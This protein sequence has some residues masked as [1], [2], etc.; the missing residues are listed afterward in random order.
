MRFLLSL[1]N[2]IARRLVASGG[3]ALLFVTGTAAQTV[4]A[5]VASGAATTPVSDAGIRP[6]HLWTGAYMRLVWDDAV[7][8][9]TAPLHW[10]DGQ[11]LK[12]GGA[13]AAV[14]ITVPFD[15]QI[16][17]NVQ[18][19]RTSGQDRFF[20]HWQNFGS[21]YSFI[22]LGGFEA[23]GELGGDLRAKNV[24]MDGL[25]ASIIATGLIA[26]TVKFVVGR[27]R[28]SS[29][30]GAFKFHPF[31]SNISFP[32]GHAAQAFAVATVI[33]GNYPQWWVGTLAYGSAA[34]VGYARVEQNAHFTSDVV[35]GAIIGWS[36]GKSIVHRHDGPSDPR[37]LSWAPYVRGNGGGLIF[38]KAF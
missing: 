36:V 8:V 12:A 32:S 5:P 14:A 25:A 34:L 27:E 4:T 18:A 24:A 11:W 1:T 23:C 35:A 2:R 7:S 37:K 29:N 17:R 20:S 19:H 33:A 6:D 28:P 30:Q 26:P 22:L 16:K 21:S 9:V 15:D 13:I 10:D 31:T 38:A 3:L